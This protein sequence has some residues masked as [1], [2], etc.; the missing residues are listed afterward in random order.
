[1][2]SRVSFSIFKPRVLKLLEEVRKLLFETLLSLKGEKKKN[3]AH[4]S[5]E[6]VSEIEEQINC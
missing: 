5:S 6:I 2:V 3:I 1:V 4:D